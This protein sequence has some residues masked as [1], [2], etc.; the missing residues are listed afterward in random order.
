MEKS[1]KKLAE[2]EEQLRKSEDQKENELQAAK[3]LCEEGSE[4]LSEALRSKN[5]SDTAVVSGLLEVAEK[6]MDSAMEQQS[7]VSVNESYLKVQG[8]EF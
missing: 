6:R 5:F 3:A 7:H 2:K 4:R 1:R 8:R